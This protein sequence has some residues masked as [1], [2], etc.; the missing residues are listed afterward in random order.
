M[1][2]NL[3]SDDTF[4][5]GNRH[6]RIS[7]TFV[8]RYDRVTLFSCLIRHSRLRPVLACGAPPQTASLNPS[9][10]VESRAKPTP[11]TF[12]TECLDMRHRP[13][14]ARSEDHGAVLVG[15]NHFASGFYTRGSAY[16]LFL[17]YRF[18]QWDASGCELRELRPAASSRRQGDRLSGATS[19]S[20]PGN[21]SWLH[22]PGPARRYG[23]TGS[24]RFRP[25]R[26]R[27]SA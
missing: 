26:T 14:A 17:L 25:R 2:C 3:L 18:S 24:R 9:R 22:A 27:W 1:F 11:M 13:P 23:S 6:R 8:F 19:R 16:C 10:G 4:Q 7:R 21:F 15:T 20:A 5:L 12:S